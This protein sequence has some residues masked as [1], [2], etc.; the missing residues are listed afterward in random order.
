MYFGL[1]IK[2][3][4][5]LTLLFFPVSLIFMKLCSVGL[6]FKK[7]KMLAVLTI[8]TQIIINI[9]IIEIYLYFSREKCK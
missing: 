7:K 8:Q 4:L 6:L 1:S 9:R 2:S 5:A 3:V